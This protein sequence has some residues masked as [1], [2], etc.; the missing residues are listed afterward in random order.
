MNQYEVISMDTWKRAVHFS[1]FRNSAQPQYCVSMELDLS[2][3]LKLVREKHY[4]FTMAFIYAVT[5][6]AN[7]VEEFRYRFL[8]GQVVLFDRIDTSFTYLNP[9]TELFK[10][11]QVPILETMEAYVE[12]AS[13]KAK[14]QEEYFTGPMGI[15]VFQFSPFPWVSF[16]NI[17]HTD[18]GKKDQATPI[19]DWGKYYEKN[20]KTVMPFSIQVH[21]SFV[22]GVHIGKFIEKLQQYLDQDYA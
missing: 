5:K 11:V 12:M 15:D 18:S 9:E 2:N 14:A 8:D 19:F 6:C 16:L 13:A 10:V 1:V 17:S 22:D 7:E 21:H 20:G 3:F 4:S